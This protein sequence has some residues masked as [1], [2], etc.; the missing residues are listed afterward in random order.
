MA[1][2]LKTIAVV[3]KAP[4]AMV[5]DIFRSLVA[6]WRPSCRVAGVIAET[7]GLPDRGCSAGY[8]RNIVTDELFPIF[9]DLGPGSTVCHL[10]GGG[11]L[12]A[13]QAVERDIAAGCDLVLLS[14][15]GKLEAGGEGLLPAFTAAV[16]ARVPLLTSVSPAFEGAWEKFAPS[17]FVALPADPD[18][19][20]AWW[21]AARHALLTETP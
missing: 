20:D 2:S 1:G 12:T 3:Q 4:G 16:R 5:Q 10:E 8:L 18:K 11:A 15:F 17:A 13:A 14:K 9:H 7:H 19:I 6:R 21:Q